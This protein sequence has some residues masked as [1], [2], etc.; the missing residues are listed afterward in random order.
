[1]RKKPLLGQKVYGLIFIAI[2]LLLIILTF[3]LSYL[4]R[5]C[6]GCLRFPCEIHSYWWY[7][8]NMFIYTA[9]FIIIFAITGFGLIGSKPWARK[10]CLYL[11]A[12]F[13]Y[14]CT[15]FL[16]RVYSAFHI[17]CI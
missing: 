8:D 11:G 6:Q 12:P 4:E 15:P 9:P 17:Y 14:I 13:F 16:Y 7:F 2:S 3:A 1:M 5:S 10:L